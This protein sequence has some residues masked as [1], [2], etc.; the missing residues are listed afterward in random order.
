MKNF[1]PKDYQSK[2]PSQK[3][4]IQDVPSGES[5]SFDVLFVGAGPASLAAALQLSRLFKDQKLEIAVIEKASRLG[6]HSL[7]GA[8]INPIAFD[9]LFPELDH[10]QLPFR[11]K[12]KK[13][14]MYFLTPKSKLRIPIPPTMHNKGFYTSSLC[15]V[16]RF[17]GKK[18]E[19]AGIHIFPSTAAEKLIIK[20]GRVKGVC[21]TA[22]GLNKN[23]EPLPQYQAPFSILAENTFLAD[24]VRGNLSQAYLK[25]NQISSYYPEHYALG[26]KEIWRVKQAPASVLHTIGWPLDG[27]GGSWLYPLSDTEISIGLVGGLDFKKNNEDLSHRF[28]KMKE[29]PF[30]K[31]ILEGGECLEWGAKAIPE[32]GYN[33][34]P[35]RLSGD[36]V[37]ILGDAAGL[38]N[39]PSLKGIHYAMLSGMLA[40]EHLYDIKTNKKITQTFT[41]RLKEHAQI[42]K[43]LFK[44][45]NIVQTLQESTLI[46]GI[47]KAGLMV[48]TGGRFPKDLAQPSRLT[49]D[50]EKL[51]RVMETKIEKNSKSE[52]VYLSGNQTRDDVPSHLDA[53][54]D[55]PKAVQELYVHLCPAGVYEINANGF[56]INSPNCIDCKA[57]DI[58]GPWWSPREGG[59]GPDYSL[60]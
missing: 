11:K 22:V 47:V 39:V 19:E 1:L 12:V 2:F 10:S 34:I 50:A 45:R 33:A 46:I 54:E 44:V 38:V 9:Q 36:G 6:G 27:F 26:I 49:S 35:D 13:E 30:F 42:G 41:Q 18:A 43:D 57:T 32:G 20:D 48:L 21:T 16:V 7:S 56:V 51:K 53:S 55:L 8:V 29:H 31:N 14:K 37:F 17:L 58:L 40:A 23:K 4:I 15:E 60:M 5:M 25:A 3:R 24:G 28:Q 59:S 52:Q